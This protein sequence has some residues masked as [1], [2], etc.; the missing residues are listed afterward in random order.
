VLFRKEAIDPADVLQDILDNIVL[1]LPHLG[2][3]V[4]I[5][6][7]FLAT[8][9]KILDTN[10]H[11]SP[12]DYGYADV[13]AIQGAV[14][15]SMPFQKKFTA[16]ELSAQPAALMAQVQKELDADAN[17]TDSSVA[18]DVTTLERSS[19]LNMEFLRTLQAE[20]TAKYGIG[21]IERWKL[22]P[23]MGLKYPF[24]RSDNG[25]FEVG[26]PF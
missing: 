19:N 14:D 26:D 9:K 24:M 18:C 13:N 7:L 11:I 12:Y 1:E 3:A 5:S 20:F 15:A 6:A 4:L 8:R 22:R 21:D 17:L 23:A 25:E 10:C 16:E 2:V